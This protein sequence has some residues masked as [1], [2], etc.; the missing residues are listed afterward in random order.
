MKPFIVLALTF[1]MLAAPFTA[2]AQRRTTDSSSFQYRK[3][4]AEQRKTI[5][6]DLHLEE[7][8]KAPFWTVY[9]SY[10]R[11]IEYLELE[12]FQVMA[13]YEH[14]SGDLNDKQ[15]QMLSRLLL[16]NDCYLAQV[17][18]QYFKKFERV[19]SVSKATEFMQLDYSLRAACRL[20]LQQGNPAPERPVETVYS[21]NTP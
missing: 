14:H 6:R 4:Q 21:L 18:R 3:W 12:Y 16:K 2:G 8:Q 19:L 20:S 5:Q 1:S 17:R 9:E 15:K 13:L 11:A 7:F 10:C